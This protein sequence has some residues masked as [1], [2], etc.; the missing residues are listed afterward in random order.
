M[1]DHRAGCAAGHGTHKIFLG[2]ASGVGKTHAMLEEAHRRKLRGQDVVIGVVESRGRRAVEQLEAG[3]ERI[4]PKLIGDQSE[5]DVEA[6]LCRK[7]TMVLIDDLQHRNPPES[8][9]DTRWEDVMEILDAGIRVTS[10]L[11][12]QHLESLNRSVSELA[13][14]AIPETVPDLVLHDADEIEYVD[15]TPRALMHRL[16]RGDIFPLDELDSQTSAFYREGKLHVL[17][18]IAMRKAAAAV[19]DDLLGIDTARESQVPDIARDRVMICVSPARSAHRLIRRGWRIGRRAHGQI[20]AVYV[21]EGPTSEREHRNL[22]EDFKFAERLG[23]KTFTLYGEL[24]PALIDFARD[25]HI[26]QLILGHPQRNRIQDGPKT[27]V[28]TELVRALRS[29]DIMVVS[30]ESAVGV[31]A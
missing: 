25:R 14:I 7:P 26:T 8:R 19:D 28:L 23:I 21:E 17:R 30:N 29:V 1:N 13:G 18:E 12:I 24:I 11:N 9:R 10:T 5:L 16:D 20:F 3:L 31:E 4:P 15:L 22:E 27:H 6:V 2:Y